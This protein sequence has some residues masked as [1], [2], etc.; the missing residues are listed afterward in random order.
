MFSSYGASDMTG[1]RSRRPAVISRSSW[2]TKEGED[3]SEAV[4]AD[5]VGSRVTAPCVKVECQERLDD[6]A[7]PQRS[8]NAELARARRYLMAR[9]APSS[10]FL[11]F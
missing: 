6:A 9:G 1:T 8:G 11:F 10:S 7:L 5:L 3:G 2:T 4:L